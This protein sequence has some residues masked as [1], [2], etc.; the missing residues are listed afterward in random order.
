VGNLAE[1]SPPKRSGTKSR[2]RSQKS[3]AQGLNKSLNTGIK[4]RP[5]IKRLP[6]RNTP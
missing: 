5:M 3:G 6:E 1:K 4:S 2:A